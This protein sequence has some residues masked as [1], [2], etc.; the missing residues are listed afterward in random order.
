MHF[1]IES[2]LRL[3]ASLVSHGGEPRPDRNR[4]GEPVLLYP[5]RPGT[6]VF[7]LLGGLFAIYVLSD[8]TLR[9]FH[10]GIT[11]IRPWQLALGL[12]L[13][14]VATALLSRTLALEE[15]GIR[16]RSAFGR[17]T[18]IPFSDMHHVERYN[19]ASARK[20]TWFLRSNRDP[21]TGRHTT[22]TLP[23]MTYNVEHLLSEIRQRTSL[24]EL[25]RQKRHW[26]G[27]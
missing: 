10:H 26:Y 23:E 20:A 16:L 9:V 1:L 25:P 24:P 6:F 5:L 14:I 21:V 7:L 18:F 11:A 17:N 13:G 3:F 19:S 27:G 4:S 15:K 2:L 8:N 12:F 22:I